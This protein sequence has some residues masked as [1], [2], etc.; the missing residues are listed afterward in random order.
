M[1]PMGWKA[2]APKSNRKYQHSEYEDGQI[3]GLTC[4]FRLQH[5]GELKWLL[6]SMKKEQ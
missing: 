4:Y 1:L 6:R 5:Y 2:M 3:D